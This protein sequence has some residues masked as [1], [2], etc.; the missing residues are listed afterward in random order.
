V[1]EEALSHQVA[2]EGTADSVQVQMPT[3]GPVV[4]LQS[5][6]QAEPGHVG[7]ARP[8]CLRTGEAAGSA[9]ASPG[10]VPGAAAPGVHGGL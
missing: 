9:V 6:P 5:Q 2:A 7:D 4:G 1:A 8:A 10:P 3:E